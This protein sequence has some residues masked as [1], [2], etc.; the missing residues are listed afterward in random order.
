MAAERPGDGP[1]PA[2]A[3]S[4]PVLEVRDDDRG[5]R[6]RARRAARLLRRRRPPEHRREPRQAHGRPRP[7]ARLRGRRVRRAPGATPALDRRPDDRHRRDGGHEHVG[8]LRLLP[9][10]RPD[11]RRLPGRGP[12]R[13][14]REH[15]HDR[16]RRV[17]APEDAAARVGRRLRD[18]DQRAP[19]LRDHAPVGALL[20]GADRLPDLARE[21]RRRREV[22]TDPARAGLAGQ[23]SIRRGHGPRDLALRRDRRDAPRLPSTRARP[24]TRSARRSAGSRTS[25]RRSL[26]R[27]RPHRRSSGSSA[28]SSTRRGCTPGRVRRAPAGSDP[29]RRRV[30]RTSSRARGSA[31]PP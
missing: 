6:P 24:S 23:R 16:H 30:S 15:Q 19:G 27:P 4:G 1:T 25:P 10:G 20:R 13:P 7:G 3:S 5:G 9:A 12:D 17:R 18:R 2:A 8:A 29:E 22:G 14:L 21:P 28:R 11:R 26:R 31:A